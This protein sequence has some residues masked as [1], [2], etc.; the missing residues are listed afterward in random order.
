MYFIHVI[1]ESKIRFVT[2]ISHS[3]L[4]CSLKPSEKAKELI[5][6]LIQKNRWVNE[7][8]Q[9]NSETSE[10]KARETTGDNESVD[11]L[12]VKELIEGENTEKSVKQ[13]LTDEYHNFLC[14]V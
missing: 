2:V 14:K 12:A 6:P 7:D 10:V 5:I 4:F 9:G 1:R 3:I 8:S 13:S 11:S